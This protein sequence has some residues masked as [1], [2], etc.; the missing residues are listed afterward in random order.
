MRSPGES[1]KPLTD[2][3]VAGILILLFLGFLVGYLWWGRFEYHKPLWLASTYFGAI[4]TV[5]FSHLYFRDKREELGIRLDNFF[6]ALKVAAIPNLF[7]LAI[8][9]MWGLLTRGLSSDLS[10]SILTYLPWA[11]LQQ[12]ILQNFLLARLGTI[13]GRTTLAAATAALVFA[14]IHLP[15]SGLVVAS[16]VGALVW[17]KIFLKVPN[18]LV[19]SLS[20]ALLGILLVVFFKFSGFDQLHVGRPGF[21][22]RS[23]GDGVL[24]ASGYDES[25]QPF[26]ATL[27]GHDRGNPSLLRVF[28]SSGR[29]SSEWEAFPDYDFSGNLAVGELGFRAGDEIVVAPGPGVRNPPEIAV[30]DTSGV[31]INR[32]TLD[33]YPGYGAVVSIADGRILVCP[34]PGPNRSARLFEYMPDGSLIKEW[35]FGEIGFHNSVRAQRLEISGAG[36]QIRTSN[37]LLWA[38]ALS[39][40][41]S[42]IHVYN[43]SK[44][45]FSTWESYGTAFG[46]NLALIK[47]EEDRVGI[48][49]GPGSAP[50]H[51]PRIKVFDESGRELRDLFGYEDDAPCGTHVSALDL[52]GDSTDEIVLGEGMCPDQPAVVRIVDRQGRLIS[53]WDA[54]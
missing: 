4:A 33:Q 26:V 29:M 43:E 42:E 30:F 16:L 27:P 47:L 9:L 17:C 19:V 31:E 49:T 28:D 54:Y 52:D 24:V 15:N 48:V 21:A 6:R 40:N 53:Q 12:Y 1:F 38:N 51:S 18:L 10:H 36:G 7:L 3:I 35:D 46:L 5:L 11:L 50:G 13:M 23:Y 34:G 20:H 37:L 14:L 41:T 2:R 32:F 8:M 45:A 22:Y 25:G 39:V 44:N